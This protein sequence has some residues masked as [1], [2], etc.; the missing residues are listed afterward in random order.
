MGE[1]DD[2]YAICFEDW[3]GSNHQIITWLC[4][5]STPSVHKASGGY[6]T[7]KEVWV[8]LASRYSGSDGAREHNLMVTLYQLRQ[9]PG[10]RVIAFHCCICFLYDRLTT[11]KPIIKTP[12]EAKVISAHHERVQLHQFLMG[13]YHEF[14]SVC[15]QLL[16]LT[17]LPSVNKMV[18]ELGCEDV[19]L[20]SPHS[21]HIPLP[22]IVVTPVSITTIDTSFTMPHGPPQSKK[23][24]NKRFNKNNVICKFYKA[25]GHTMEQC[26]IRAHIL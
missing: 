15:S 24:D 5:T 20:L 21:S 25:K 16:H 6:N 13:I 10:E 9:Q 1:T 23:N 18:N 8:M 11:S 2:A 19:C 7:S 4:N 14:E 22:T 12:S 26:R 17:P 3:D